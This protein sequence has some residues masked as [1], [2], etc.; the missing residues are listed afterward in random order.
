[1]PGIFRGGAMAQDEPTT[2]ALSLLAGHL[3]PRGVLSRIAKGRL[4]TVNS[5]QFV[6]ADAR[7]PRII[8][9][10]SNASISNTNA[11][12]GA[13]MGTTRGRHLQ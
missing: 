5:V 1:M 2:V 11:D 3:P 4:S 6:F 8:Y 7:G 13:G 9:D 10:K 12:H